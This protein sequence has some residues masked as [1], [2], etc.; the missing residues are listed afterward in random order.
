MSAILKRSTRRGGANTPSF[1]SR[2]NGTG[3]A[4]PPDM[5]GVI[6]TRTVL[7]HLPLI[8]RE[9]GARVAV[10]CLAAVLLRRRTTFLELVHGG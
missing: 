6:T 2:A 3:D 1:L 9:F 10:R 8:W 5:R 4:P 7:R